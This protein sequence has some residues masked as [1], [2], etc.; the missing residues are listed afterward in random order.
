[1]KQKNQKSKNQRN[2]KHLKRKR[3][4]SIQY[5]KIF[6]CKSVIFKYYFHTSTFSPV[7]YFVV[8]LPI[9]VQMQNEKFSL[10][11]F[12][13]RIHE[14]CLEASQFGSCCSTRVQKEQQ[15]EN[16]HK[17]IWQIVTQN[18]PAQ[19]VC[20]D[21]SVVGFTYKYSAAQFN[22]QNFETF[23]NFARD[24]QQYVPSV[25]IS[26]FFKQLMEQQ[27][28]VFYLLSNKAYLKDVETRFIILNTLLETIRKWKEN[29]YFF[30]INR[31]P[32]MSFISIFTLCITRNG[33]VCGKINFSGKGFQY[34]GEDFRVYIEEIGN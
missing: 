12:K 24:L 9:Q 10:S 25:Y 21:G 1:M 17:S 28:L 2:K 32:S 16:F 27:S 31:E 6:H 8:Y 11:E 19:A 20:K 4:N 22:A 23:Y 29:Q 5:N 33:I 7:G 18:V 3:P 30:Y 26:L 14:F 13:T 34:S 15:A